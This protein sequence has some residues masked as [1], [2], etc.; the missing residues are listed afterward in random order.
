MIFSDKV[1]DILWG[2]VVV[3]GF[4]CCILNFFSY[5]NKEGVAT[6]KARDNKSVRLEYLGGVG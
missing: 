6:I 2:R 4:V 1:G 3:D 5:A